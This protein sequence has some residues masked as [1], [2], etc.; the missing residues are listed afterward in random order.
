MT[1][2]RVRPVRRHRRE[3]VA[4]EHDLRAERDVV[5]GQRV[6]VA[7]AVP[8]L[9]A[10]ADEP[11]DADERGSAGDDALADQRVA[12]QELPLGVV[13]LAGLVQQRARDRDLADVVQLGRGRDALDRPRR[14]ARARARCRRP[15]SPRPRRA[16]SAR[17]PTRRRRAAARSCSARAPRCGRCS[18]PR[19]ARGRRRAVPRRPRTRRSGMRA[20][21]QEAPILKPSPCVDSARRVRAISSSTGRSDVPRREHAELVAAHPVGAAPRRRPSPAAGSRAG[22]AERRPPGG[23]SCRCSA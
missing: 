14:R 7:A 2:R 3:R 21:P 5:A 9:V 6:R 11:G 10:G 13:E 8:A 22:A 23:R 17:R 12:A 19:T 1:R 20:K 18:S 4:H 16:R 15:A